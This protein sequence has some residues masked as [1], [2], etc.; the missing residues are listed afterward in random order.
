MKCLVSRTWLGRCFNIGLNI[1]SRQS[2]IL[3]VGE[4]MPD[5]IGLPGFP[6]LCIF[7]KR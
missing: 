4:L 3:S 1:L 7:G 2:D 6:S 5:T